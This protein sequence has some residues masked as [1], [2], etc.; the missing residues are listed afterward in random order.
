M[1]SPTTTLL[2]IS[3]GSLWSRIVHVANVRYVSVMCV[4]NARDQGS[5]VQGPVRLHSREG[6]TIRGGEVSSLGRK[7]RLGSILGPETPARSQFAVNELICIIL[8]YTNMNITNT[9]IY[10]YNMY[11]YIYIYIYVHTHYN[12]AYYN[13][14]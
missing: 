2:N 6:K 11:I 1:T 14:V 10:I 7:T 5:R 9:Y 8:V 13:S 4:L 3:S 12:I